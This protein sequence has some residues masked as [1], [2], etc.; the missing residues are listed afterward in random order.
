MI[1]KKF[2]LENHHNNIGMKMKLLNLDSPDVV[3]FRYI[4]PA[5][6]RD[7]SYSFDDS[8]SQ[9][10]T[11]QEESLPQKANVACIRLDKNEMYIILRGSVK[12]MASKR[13]LGGRL[14]KPNATFDDENLQMN[15]I[16]NVQQHSMNS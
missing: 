7:N 13:I 8:S 10:L 5:E 12:I 6:M 4:H 3:K 16:L 1:S 14:D 2:F 11:S 15:L 9:R